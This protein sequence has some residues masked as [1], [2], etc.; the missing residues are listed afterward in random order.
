MTEARRAVGLA[1]WSLGHLLAVGK[2]AADWLWISVLAVALADIALSMFRGDSPDYQPT[3]RSD[4]IA[5]VAGLV[6][7]IILL[8]W[9]HPYV[10]GVNP[11]H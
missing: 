1:L 8:V 4:I 5:V 6:L 11:L 9:F 2:W 10:L 7:T 3:W